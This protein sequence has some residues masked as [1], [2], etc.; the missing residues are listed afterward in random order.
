MEGRREGGVLREGGRK[1]AK[2]E[3]EKPEG[4]MKDSVSR[5]GGRKKDKETKGK[6][7][8]EEGPRER[9]REEKR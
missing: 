7:K 9:G 4:E 6:G 5:E 8:E 3:K 1:K 2:E